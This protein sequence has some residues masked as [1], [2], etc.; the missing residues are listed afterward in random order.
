MEE[1]GILLGSILH[2]DSVQ[3]FE[4]AAKYLLDHFRDEQIQ[5]ICDAVGKRHG[6][7]REYLIMKLT[8]ERLVRE[9]GESVI[10][11]GL[12]ASGIDPKTIQKARV[13]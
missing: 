9:Q 12:R 5:W 8:A 2:N 11:E 4:T 1:I 13:G 7:D 10:D 3:P 6:K